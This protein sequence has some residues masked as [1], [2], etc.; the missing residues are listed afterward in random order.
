MVDND[1]EYQKKILGLKLEKQELQ[2]KNLQNKIDKYNRVND[3]VPNTVA[4]QD[5]DDLEVELQSTEIEL[6]I[7]QTQLEA[8]GLKVEEQ[9]TS[10]CSKMTGIITQNGEW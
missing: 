8:L 9:C 7:I 6:E 5:I 2:N 4:Q 3:K 1:L 10:Q